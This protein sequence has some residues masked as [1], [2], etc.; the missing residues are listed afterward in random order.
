MRTYLILKEKA[1]RFNADKEIQQVLSDLRARGGGQ[2]TMP[3]FTKDGADII[4]HQTLDLKAI[5]DHG[6]NYE[7]LDQ[8]TIEVLLGVR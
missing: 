6:F 8:L 4:K 5:R 1:A 2:Q 7:R 3:R